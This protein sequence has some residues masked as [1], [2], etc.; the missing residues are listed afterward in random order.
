MRMLMVVVLANIPLFITLGVGGVTNPAMFG[1]GFVIGGICV[2]GGIILYV[3][4]QSMADT[5]NDDE[6]WRALVSQ[7]YEYTRY[8]MRNDGHIGPMDKQGNPKQ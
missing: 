7:K 5:R 1:L 3:W 2:A 4:C 8:G 6:E